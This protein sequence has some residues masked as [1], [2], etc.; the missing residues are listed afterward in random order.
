[1]NDG[2]GDSA[3]GASANPPQI[4]FSSAGFDPDDLDTFFSAQS[5]SHV[6]FGSQVGLDEDEQEDD[7]DE[8]SAGPEGEDDGGDDLDV[9]TF[10]KT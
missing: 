5:A 3:A 8:D 2:A 10:K 6:S 9:Q 7:E 1:M 4:D